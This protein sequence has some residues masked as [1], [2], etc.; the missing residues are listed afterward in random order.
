MLTDE[1]PK[2]NTCTRHFEVDASD[3]FLPYRL[4]E[5]Y[6]VVLPLRDGEYLLPSSL[7]NKQPS[8]KIPNPGRNVFVNR[9]YNLAYLPPSFW[10]RLIARVQTF[11]VNLYMDCKKQVQQWNE[12]VFVYWTERAF[13]VISHGSTNPCA[14]TVVITTP[15]TEHGAN[16]LAHVVDHLDTL[17]EEW[18]PDLGKCSSLITY[19]H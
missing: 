13:F 4:L 16:I 3:V 7:S 2:T 1:Q 17:L 5:H 10:P 15:S 19:L 9:K 18:F 11:V 8:I 12:G 6:C 14:E